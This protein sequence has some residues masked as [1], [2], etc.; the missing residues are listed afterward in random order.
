M[1]AKTIVVIGASSG[2]IDALRVIM[3][4]LP[5]DLPAAI[6]VVVH[7]AGNAPG[8]LDSILG[9][10]GALRVR[11]AATGMP[12]EEREV[13][14]APPDYHLLIEPGHLSLTK[15]PKENRFRPAIDALFRSA[16]Q[17]YGP[18]AIGVVLTGNLDDGTAGLW[19]IKR[20]GGIAVVQDPADAMFP[21]MPANAARYVDVDHSVPASAMAP[22]LVRLVSM[23]IDRRGVIAPEDLEIEMKI[24]REENPIEAGIERISEPSFVACPECHGVLMRLKNGGQA[25]F[26]CH[27]GHA[28]SLQTL[29]AAL[30]DGVEESL[31]NSVRALQEGAL[32]LEHVSEHVTEPAEADSLKAQSSATKHQ[33]DIVR[34]V[35]M[36]REGLRGS[37]A[38]AAHGSLSQPRSNA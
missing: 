31:W 22:L 38:E 27:T 21:S 4:G 26:R 5:R 1:A 34:G 6:C 33:A 16:A 12:I 23:P 9:R 15:G 18:A 29:I 19:A 17:V 10:A 13:Y 25:R 20:L 3:A 30:N 28:Y 35:I 36:S 37:P 14:V 32:L 24:A 2:G 11:N 7:T 8:I